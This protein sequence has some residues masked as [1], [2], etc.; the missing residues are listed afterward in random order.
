MPIQRVHID[1]IDAYADGDM[2]HYESKPFTGIEYGHYDN[3]QL[4]REVY[5]LEGLQHGLKRLWYP[6]GQ[7]KSEALIIRGCG[8]LGESKE[9]H[10]NGQLKTRELR[11]YGRALEVEEYDEAGELIRSESYPPKDK[12][13]GYT[14]E[15]L[16]RLK[17]HLNELPQDERAE[18][19]YPEDL[20][21][22]DELG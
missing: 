19:Y 10:E 11:H 20:D 5:F 1:D 12:L 6:N 13:S 3:G 8:T 4:E 9:W 17:D 16:K 21:R 22:L 14:I 7:L 15:A 2:F 18:F